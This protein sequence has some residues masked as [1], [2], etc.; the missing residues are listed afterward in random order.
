MWLLGKLVS[1]LRS[2]FYYRCHP[3]RAQRVEGPDDLRQPQHSE[4]FSHDLQLL[5]LHRPFARVEL[6]Q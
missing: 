3:E 4:A 5:F 1:C 2:S 6:C